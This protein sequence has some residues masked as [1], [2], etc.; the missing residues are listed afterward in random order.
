MKFDKTPFLRALPP[1]VRQQMEISLYS[2]A[3]VCW[4]VLICSRLAPRK[5]ERTLGADMYVMF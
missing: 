4:L 2:T 5:D 3:L 1:L